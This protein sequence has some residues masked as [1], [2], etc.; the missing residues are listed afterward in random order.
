M[1]SQSVA[2]IGV[3][4]IG[5][6]WAAIFLAQGYDVRASDPSPQGEAFARRFIANAWPTLEASGHSA[7]ER[8]PGEP[9]QL[10]RECQTR[11]HEAPSALSKPEC[12]VRSCE[13]HDS[14]RGAD[15]MGLR[16]Y[17]R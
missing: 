6:S 13:A 5:A 4:T 12:F 7:N 1:P 11:P 3:G 16:S 9:G 15:V 2:V 14:S 10:L 17:L 8:C